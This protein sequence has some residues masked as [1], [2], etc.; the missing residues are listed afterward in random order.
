VG[1]F[2]PI[3]ELA[4]GLF[5]LDVAGWPLFWTLFFTA[6]TYVN[7]GWLREQV[8]LYMCPYARFQSAMI[9]RDTLIVS[10]DSK[11]GDP[12]GSRKRG[13]RP[14]NLGDCTDCQLCVQVCPTGIDIRNGLQYQCIGC[15]HCID[16]CAEVMDK[17]GYAPGLIR[18]TTLRALDGGNVRILRGRSIGYALICGVLIVAFGVA[19]L[20]RDLLVID[21]VRPRDA[22]YHTT[23]DGGIVNSYEIRL[24]NK[25]QTVNTY[26]L[27][28]VGDD[29]TLTQ[30]AGALRLRSPEHITVPPGSIET[31][32]VELH[33]PAGTGYRKV[34][35]RACNAGGEQCD[36]EETVFMTPATGGR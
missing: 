23:F 29:G 32:N 1:Y 25:T 11:R 33:A 10:Y 28:L 24:A 35:L 36:Q 2:T 22:L 3:R 18:Y 4:T 27:G 15:A 8:C 6:A 9:D 34:S 20:N 13:T 26:R 30:S 21:I 14:E 7:A 19:L 17:M 5:N 31:F 12:R 16:A